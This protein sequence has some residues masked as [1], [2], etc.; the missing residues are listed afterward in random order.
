MDGDT[1]PN[2]RF[3]ESNRAYWNEVTPMH[4]DSEFYGVD[5]FLAGEEI[6][7][8]HE[9]D[10]LGDVRGKRLLHLQCHFGLDT[11][12]WA[13]LGADVTGVDISDDSIAKALEL[14]ERAQLPARFE[15]LDVLE[16]P[17]P[18]SGE[19]FDII[20]TG[21][22]ALCW[23]PD[24]DRWGRAVS[25][26]LTPGGRL[27]LMETHPAVYLFNDRGG[28]PPLIVDGGYFHNEEPLV[29]ES[30]GDSDYAEMGYRPV[31]R[32]YEWRWSIADMVN[33]MIRH[34]LRIERLDELDGLFFQ[35][36]D[37]MERSEDGMWRFADLEVKLPM[38]IA[39]LA[40]KPGGEQ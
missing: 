20:Y 24:L 39:L 21:R 15:R 8:P 38:T 3:I 16:L 37:G 22:G 13:R 6:L 33:T 35:G 9:V 28:P 29:E 11:L 1:R 5:R 18:L 27:Y 23:L 7:H 17:G 10:A 2:E 25:E 26:L 19:T 30:G 4:A 34:G 32:S 31:Q 12:A 36:F 14:A 40:N